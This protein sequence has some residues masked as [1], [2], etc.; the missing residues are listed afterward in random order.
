M[1][2]MRRSGGQPPFTTAGNAPID[3]IQ[4][5]RTVSTNPA[6]SEGRSNNGQIGLI[7]MAMRLWIVAWFNRTALTAT[8]GFA[9]LAGTSSA[10]AQQCGSIGGRFTIR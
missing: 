1:E 10:A 9:V 2:S 7:P 5:F 3:A 8:N 6:A 4:E